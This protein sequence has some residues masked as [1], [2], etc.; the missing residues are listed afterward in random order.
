MCEK[1]DEE[2]DELIFEARIDRLNVFSS[3]NM[4]VSSYGW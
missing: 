4:L 2:M 3:F 1:F